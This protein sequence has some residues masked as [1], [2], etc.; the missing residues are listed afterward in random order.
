MIELSYVYFILLF[1]FLQWIGIIGRSI[2]QNSRSFVKREVRHDDYDDD[3]DST[4][5]EGY[6]PYK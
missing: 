5:D 6:M 3:D 2:V 4:D 1:L